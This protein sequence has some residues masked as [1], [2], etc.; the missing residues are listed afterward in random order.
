MADFTSSGWS[1]YISVVTI[2]GIVFCLWLLLATSKK[3]VAGSTV[4]TTGHVWDETLQEY[5][6]PLPRWWMWLFIITI[7]FAI[8]YLVLYPGLGGRSG[9]LGWSQADQYQREIDKANATYEPLFAK[10]LAQ[11][12]KLVAADP[13]ARAMGE[14]L[15][16]TY[17][18]QCHGSN[19]QGS[20][21]FPN[22][23]DGD[24]L[25]GGE[26]QTIKE[27]ILGGRN[28][29]M[30]PMA[31]ALGGAADV[32]NVANYVLSLSGGAHDAVKAQLGKPKFGVCAACHGPEGK[33]NPAVGA[34][35][36]TDRIWLYGGSLATVT[37]SIAKGRNNPMPAFKDLL[38]EGKV[39]L[40]AAYVWGLSNTSGAQAT[41]Q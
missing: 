5:N 15:F 6:N 34:P 38:G 10:Y 29:M 8:A 35:N 28:G 21:S 12:L 23:T 31:E 30:P 33:G 27:T 1:I 14:R 19:A 20:R 11:D 25:Y 7:V 36:L 18:M 16:L 24:W 39:H 3:K 17:C 2:A 26:P 22:L 4:E 13:Q 32:E 41:K 37:E 9:T 40:L